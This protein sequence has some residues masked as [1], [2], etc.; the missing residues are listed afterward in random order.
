MPNLTVQNLFNRQVEVAPGQTLLQALQADGIDWMH[1]CGAK[2]RCT[3]CR[4][5]VQEGLEHFGPLTDSEER[6]RS[7]GRLQDNERLTCQCTLVSGDAQG[8]VPRQTML[9]HI[10]YSN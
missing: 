9:P 10:K 1:A 3:T 6:Y 2:G 5:V 7:K 4:I 8:R